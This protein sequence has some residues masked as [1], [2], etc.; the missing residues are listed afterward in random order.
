MG[1]VDLE[2]DHF[3]RYSPR[4]SMDK[5]RAPLLF[6]GGGHD[7]R[8]PV[9]EARQ[10]FA[11]MKSAGKTVEYLEFPDEGHRP[12]KMTN[13][14]KEIE[15]VLAWLGR[16]LPDP[17]SSAGLG[18]TGQ[19][20]DAL[21]PRLCAHRPDPDALPAERAEPARHVDPAVLPKPVDQ[22]RGVR[23]RRRL[24][25]RDRVRREVRRREEP[26]AE[27]REAAPDAGRHGRVPA[28]A[29][30]E[31]LLLHEAEGPVE[32]VEEV[33]GDRRRR[34]VPVPPLGLVAGPGGQVEV[35]AVH[36]GRLR[37]L[38]EGG[39]DRDGGE[40]GRGREAFLGRT[41]GRVDSE[42]LDG[43]RD[44]RER[45]HRVQQDERIRIVGRLEELAERIRDPG[46]GLVVDD[47]EG[48][49]R[50]PEG[51]PDPV[52]VGPPAP[53]GR[54][55]VRPDPGG[56]EALGDPSAEEAVLLDDD[57]VPAPQEREGDRFEPGMPGAHD[58]EDPAVRLRP[59]VPE[60]VD[61]LSV[62]V[63]ERLP[64]VRYGGLRHL[65]LDR[66][67]E[68]HGPG[69]EEEGRAHE[70]VHPNGQTLLQAV[71]TTRDRAQSRMPASETLKT[72]SPSGRLGGGRSPA[73]RLPALP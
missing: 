12:R 35:P 14:I 25:A 47:R 34:R 19:G 57:A 18:P 1:D 66:R 67:M 69:D 22:G 17:T 21:G 60:E 71:P 8:C 44:P 29:G 16:F 59:D 3:R 13:K 64:V 27:V 36:V 53:R 15:T 38:P 62:R 54:D 49:G 42:A 41:E 65:L 43:D 31:P 61:G 73:S 63:D 30:L 7:P 55:E 39:R 72:A 4:F 40:A 26:E 70:R 51:L 56:A 46:R 24:R 20:G 10:M 33:R 50:L 37:G 11:D 5:I 6:T 23:A 48:L 58:W 68:G 32:R 9:G 2:I 52:D 45:R 28:V